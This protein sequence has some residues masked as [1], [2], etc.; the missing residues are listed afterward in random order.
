M[1]LAENCFQFNYADRLS[2]NCSLLS[3]KA[4]PLVPIFANS[5]STQKRIRR[6]S[7]TRKKSVFPTNELT[8]HKL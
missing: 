4:F 5:L 3:S 7:Q 2:I 1:K 6:W 8:S